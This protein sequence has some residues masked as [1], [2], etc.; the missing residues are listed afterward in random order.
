MEFTVSKKELNRRKKAFV[1]LLISLTIGIFLFSM[2]FNFPISP[3]GFLSVGVIFL[4]LAIITIRHISS[5]AEMKICIRNEEIERLKGTAGE[6]YSI[7]GINVLRIK[8]RTNGII[9]EIYISFHNRNLCINA[10]EEQFEQLKDTLVGK[11]NKN[12]IVKEIREPLNFDHPLFYPVLGLLIGGAGVWFLK[13]IVNTDYSKMKIIL[14]SF[15]GYTLLVAIYFLF[16]KP[17]SIGAGKSQL[18]TDYI[19]GI[20]MICAAIFILSISLKLPV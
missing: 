20:I 14:S 9:R 6:K 2:L 19:F 1:T 5:L 13:Y 10:F 16:K 18:I 7:S 12:V 17:I 8:R 3:A 11:V 15:S 4:F